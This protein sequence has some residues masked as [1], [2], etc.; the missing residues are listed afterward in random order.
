MADDLPVRFT[1]AETDRIQVI[2]LSEVRLF[3][4]VDLKNRSMVYGA[5]R[6][7]LLTVALLRQLADALESG[8][9]KEG[10]S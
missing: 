8:V 1:P 6:H 2:D 4:T 9:E 5:G 7:R 10:R 3:V